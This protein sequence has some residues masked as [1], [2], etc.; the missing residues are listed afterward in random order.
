MATRP[1]PLT[2][3]VAAPAHGHPGPAAS[4]PAASSGEAISAHASGTDQA[5]RQVLGPRL[6]RLHA[7]IGAAHRQA[8]G[9]AFSRALLAG[10]VEP[11]QLVA[12]LRALAPGYALI[13]QEGPALA[14][15]LGAEAF[16]WGE[17][18]RSPVLERDAAQFAA[19]AASPPSAAASLWLEQ[20]RSL[21]RQ[22]PHRFLA[23]AYVRYGGDLSGGQQLAEQA[24][25]ILASRGLPPVGFWAFERPVRELKDGLHAAFEQL[26]LSESEEDELVE[27]AEIAFRATQSLLAEL[28]ELAP[29]TATGSAPANA[30]ASTSTPAPAP[31]PATA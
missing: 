11:L 20:L 18:A 21:A 7:R 10:Q 26:D 9:M 30:A 14:A 8:E 24:N 1:N 23:H 3:P 31:A 19:I 22:A 27:E 4:G 2:S 29:G 12:L 13:E 5:Q 15:A 25:A 6:R 16:P 28:A 17:L